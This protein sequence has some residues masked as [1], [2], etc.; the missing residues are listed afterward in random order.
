METDFSPENRVGVTPD[1]WTRRMREIT[2]LARRAATQQG[3]L[4]TTDLRQLLVSDG[5]LATF[6]RLGVLQRSRRGLFVLVGAPDTWEHRIMRACLGA[7]GRGVASHRTALHLWDLRPCDGLVEVTVRGC[8]APRLTGAIVHRSWDLEPADV[9][10]VDGLPVTSAVRTLVD[11]GVHFGDREV[12]RLVDSSLGLGLVTAADLQRFRNRVGRQGRT[13]VGALQRVLDDLPSGAGST[14][15]PMEARVLRLIRDAGLPDPV[16]QFTVVAQGRRFRIDFAYP[17]ARLLL[18]Y[19]GY[20]EHTTPERFTSDRER[21]NLLVLDGWQILRFTRTDVRDRPTQLVQQ[22]R[23]ALVDPR[24][25]L[26]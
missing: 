4:T 22:I 5:E 24:L 9:T 15:S 12:Q 17:E 18:E 23:A 20:R 3:L 8:A 14:E 7:A 1:C 6:L 25:N 2:D 19:D 10:W 13:G 11:A 21:Q 26:R 16:P